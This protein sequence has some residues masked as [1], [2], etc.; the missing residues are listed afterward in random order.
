MDIIIACI[1]GAFLG[2]GL[3]DIWLRLFRTNGFLHIRPPLETGEKDEVREIGLCLELQYG[4]DL[5]KPHKRMIFQ[6]VKDK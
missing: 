6:V 4:T 5:K 1:A 2:I 3:Y